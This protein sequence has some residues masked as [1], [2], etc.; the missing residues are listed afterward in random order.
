MFCVW[1][2]RASSTLHPSYMEN[3]D[4]TLMDN[5]LL[6]QKADRQMMQ[7]LFRVWMQRANIIHGDW[8]WYA[9]ECSSLV[10]DLLMNFVSYMRVWM[11][12]VSSSLHTLLIEMEYGTYRGG[13][14]GGGESCIEHSWCSRIE[15]TR[16]SWA[17]ARSLYLQKPNSLIHMSPSHLRSISIMNLHAEPAFYCIPCTVQGDREWYSHE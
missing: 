3:E 11:Q 4:D 10:E 6:R 1:M 13:G 5:A 14:V 17:W 9:H 8:E 12:W 15:S 2:P 16:S 7:C